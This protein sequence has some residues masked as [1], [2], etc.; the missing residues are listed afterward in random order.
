MDY[1]FMIFHI[2]FN[3]KSP[4]YI[5]RC[6]GAVLYSASGICKACQELRWYL[7]GSAILFAAES[8]NRKKE[9]LSQVKGSYWLSFESKNKKTFLPMGR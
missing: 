8:Q 2:R 4:R 1:R 7:M 5:P 3:R 6:G 9:L